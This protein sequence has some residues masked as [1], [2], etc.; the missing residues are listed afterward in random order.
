[1]PAYTISGFKLEVGLLY[2]FKQCGRIPG[3]SVENGGY[4]G[5]SP[6]R[7]EIPAELDL[8]YILGLV[9]FQK[10]VG[11]VANGIGR[12]ICGKENR[13]AVAETYDVTHT[14]TPHIQKSGVI[15]PVL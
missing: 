1:M 9:Y 11:G 8:V 12:L 5:G 13:P 3:G 2:L 4:V 15:Q 14:G 10:K 6:H 7:L